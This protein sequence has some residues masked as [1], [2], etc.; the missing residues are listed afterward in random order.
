MLAELLASRVAGLIINP[1]FDATIEDVW[2]GTPIIAV[3]HSWA[4]I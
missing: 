1:A 4:A 3:A 2:D